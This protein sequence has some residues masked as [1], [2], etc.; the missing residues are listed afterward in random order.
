M[1]RSSNSFDRS[2][3]VA[4]GPLL[5]LALPFSVSVIAFLF[6]NFK[7]PFFDTQSEL[8]CRVVG[9]SNN[10][11]RYRF[12]SQNFEGCRV[13]IPQPGNPGLGCRITRVIELIS[14]K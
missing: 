4:S 6:L 12:G 5:L 10:C 1:V 7:F 11:N 2:A 8:D 9:L 14:L 3:S 13:R